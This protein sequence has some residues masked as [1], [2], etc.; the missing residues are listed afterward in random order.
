MRSRAD[1]WGAS[2]RRGWCR[3]STARGCGDGARAP[4]LN[5]T[6]STRSAAGA[7]PPERGRGRPGGSLPRRAPFPCLS[8]CIP[9]AGT[10]EP[11]ASPPRRP[12]PAPGPGP[13]GAAAPPLPRGVEP[14][15]EDAP[16]RGPAPPRAQ[17]ERGS[18]ARAPPRLA[19]GSGAAGLGS[20]RLGSAP[21]GW[22][23]VRPAPPMKAAAGGGG[24]AAG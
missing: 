16:P 11:R 23:A 5:G 6:A 20:A 15:R 21:E 22:L 9:R 17:P 7:N 18:G 19:A 14:G 24:A 3:G 13:G 1:P 8:P 4:L 2:S 12:A 10:A